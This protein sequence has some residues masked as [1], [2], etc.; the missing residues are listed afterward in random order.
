MK[1][2]ADI[3][4]GKGTYPP[5]SALKMAVSHF[6]QWYRGDGTGS[7]PTISPYSDYILTIFYILI[8]IIYITINLII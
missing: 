7:V 3:T 1:G 4:L 8:Q 2:D 5:D 6:I